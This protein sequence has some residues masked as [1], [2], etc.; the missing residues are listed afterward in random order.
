MN[1]VKKEALYQNGTE[2]FNNLYEI[3]KKKTENKTEEI[4]EKGKSN[5]DSYSEECKHEK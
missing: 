2:E 3:N 4:D 1:F 5:K